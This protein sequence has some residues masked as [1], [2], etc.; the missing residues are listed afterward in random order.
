MIYRILRP[1]ARLA[2]LIYFR[3]IYLINADKLPK[4]GPVILLCNHPSAFME[5]CLLAC[6]LPREL[7]FLTRGDFFVSRLAT[8]FLRQTNQIP[9]YR[10][11]DGFKNLRH[12][13]ET[14]SACYNRLAEGKVILMFPEARTILE[15]RLRPIQRGAARMAFGAMV[16]KPDIQPVILPAGATFSDPRRMGTHVYFRFADPIAIDGML[17]LYKTDPQEAV[18]V[19]TA[20]IESD[21]RS[22]IIELHDERREALFNVFSELIREKESIFP[23]TSTDPAAFE[24]QQRLAGY[25]N[26][27]SDVRTDDLNGQISD[28]QSLSP[29]WQMAMSQAGW[30]RL[31]HP[32]VFG[33]VL[34][35]VI[36]APVIACMRWFLRRFVTA[37]TFVGPMKAVIGFVFQ[38]VY[39]FLL[40]LAGWQLGST[41]GFVVAIIVV[42]IGYFSVSNSHLRT[43][44]HRWRWKV[45][46]G[47][48][49]EAVRDRLPPIREALDE[50]RNAVSS[51]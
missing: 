40:L 6:F 39:Y 46:P 21:M 12:N 4:T 19:L 49:K 15:K 2:F 31:L 36:N 8:W 24:V 27:L 9:I 51:Q 35:R 34:G 38:G 44:W 45:T 25:L 41:A 30:G 37:E 32:R 13:R 14:F 5:A 48:T 10:S 1:L 18:R 28:L 43:A 42:M 26:L 33:Y 29:H 22:L 7:H 3:K 16:E 23:V 11:R 50:I 17:A 20:R 47:M